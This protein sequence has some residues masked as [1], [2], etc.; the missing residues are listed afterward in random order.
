MGAVES[1]QST[2]EKATE[3]GGEKAMEGGEEK[4]AGGEDWQRE[5]GAGGDGQ[6]LPL[7]DDSVWHNT[8]K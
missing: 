3:G 8:I 2:E 5:G 6:S 4:R 7:L 1:S